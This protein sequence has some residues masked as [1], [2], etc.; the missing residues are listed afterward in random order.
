[1]NWRENTFVPGK[2][3]EVTQELK[4]PMDSFSV[5]E[6]LRF[7]SQKYSHYDSATIYCFEKVDGSGTK[8]LFLP[9]GVEFP[10]GAFNL[11]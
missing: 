6:T 11:E 5:G 8:Q 10:V 2:E 7:V 3:Y 1:M 4:S 9:D